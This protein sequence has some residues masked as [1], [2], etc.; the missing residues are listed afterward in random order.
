MKNILNR[1]TEMMGL[2]RKHLL[3]VDDE[4]PLRELF[5]KFFGE[6]GYEM[7]LAADIAEAHKKLKA[8][9]FDLVLHDIDL[10]DGSGIDSLAF[11]KAKYPDLPVVI[12]TGHGYDEALFQ[13]ATGNGAS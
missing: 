5:F 6:R 3:F 10:P 12:L 7:T 13:A 8:E 9:Q 11:I 2:R 1:F 4:E